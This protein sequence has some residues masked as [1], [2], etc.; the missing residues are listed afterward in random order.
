MFLDFFDITELIS[1]VYDQHNHEQ[2]GWREVYSITTNTAKWHENPDYDYK[3]ADL[4]FMD[5]IYLIKTVYDGA[6][7]I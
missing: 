1:A 4:G 6:E 5:I 3:T 7:I 2:L